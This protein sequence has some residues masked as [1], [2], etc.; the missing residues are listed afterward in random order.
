MGIRYGWGCI[1]QYTALPKSCSLLLLHFACCCLSLD[2]FVPASMLLVLVVLLLVCVICH[3]ISAT[4]VTDSNLKPWPDINKRMLPPH[5]RALIDDHALLVPLPL[6]L[7]FYPTAIGS[8]PKQPGYNSY[9][10]WCRTML[11]HAAANLVILC[12]QCFAA[13]PLFSV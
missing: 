5:K 1:C 13:S 4:G 9:P 12:L 11:G 3:G 7:L 8:E 6:Q 2:M 10:H